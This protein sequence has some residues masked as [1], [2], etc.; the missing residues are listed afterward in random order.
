[1]FAVISLNKGRVGPM[2][3]CTPFLVSDLEAHV[4]K[5]KKKQQKMPHTHKKIIKM[6]TVVSTF[7]EKQD[8]VVC[9]QQHFHHRHQQKGEIGGKIKLITL[10]IRLH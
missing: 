6:K 9:N 1:M 8:G 5:E 3:Q 10:G 4:K 2:S 7:M